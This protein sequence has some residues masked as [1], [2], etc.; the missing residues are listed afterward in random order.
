MTGYLLWSKVLF[1]ADSRLAVDISFNYELETGKNQL[2]SLSSF[3]LVSTLPWSRLVEFIKCYSY[4]DSQTIRVSADFVVCFVVS[5]LWIISREY[6]RYSF[7][8][9]CFKTGV[10]FRR[11][12]LPSLINIGHCLFCYR[13]L[14]IALDQSP[15]QVKYLNMSSA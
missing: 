1:R 14:R 12:C 15:E 13:G 6:L 9:I 4:G 5:T 11:R 2:L 8:S 10:F 3:S 7:N